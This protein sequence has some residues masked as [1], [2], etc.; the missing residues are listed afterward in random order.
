MPAATIR[1]APRVQ[2]AESRAGL[3]REGQL[4]STHVKRVDLTAPAP[5]LLA[6]E[7]GPRPRGVPLKIGFA[8]AV[9]GLDSE[10]ATASSLEWE[11]ENDGSHVAAIIVSSPTAAAIRAGLLVTDLPQDAHVR[12]QAPGATQLFEFTGREILDAIARNVVAGD[13]SADAHT[14]WSPVIEGDAIAAEI[15]LA[16]GTDPASV[17]LS[18]PT[19][20]HLATSA[21]RDF[22]LGTKSAGCEVDAMCAIDAWGPQ[23]NAV[24][25]MVF[26]GGTGTF[27]CT[28]TLMA[29]NDATSNVP[30]FLS[31]NHCISTQTSASSLTTYWFYRTSACNARTP[32]PYQQL[33]SGA[34]LLSATTATDTSFMQLNDPPP[35]GAVFAGWLAG[36]APAVGS[37]IVGLHH[38]GGDFLRISTGTINGYLACT[39]PASGNFTCDPASASSGNYLDIAW[40]SGVTEGGSSGSGLFLGDGYLVGHLYGGSSDCSAP[41]DDIYGRFDVAYDSGLKRWLAGSTA[42][43]S[44]TLVG[45]GSGTVASTPTGI[46]CGSACSANYATGTRVDLAATPAATSTFRGW[47]GACS[48]TGACTVTLDSATS[49]SAAFDPLPSPPPASAPAIRVSPASLQFGGESMATTSPSQ[50]VT[51]TNAGNAELA[52]TSLAV[53]DAQFTQ[54]SGCTTIAPGASCTVGIAF[55]P[56]VASG[57]VDTTIAV[58]ATLVLTSNDPANPSLSIALAGTAEKSLVTHYYRSILRRAPDAT[59]KAFWQGEAARV[60]SLG[61]DVDETWHAMALQFFGSAEYAALARDDAGFVSDL[62]AAFFNRA[63]DAGGLA[64]WTGQLASGLPRDAA[65]VGFLFSPEFASFTQSIFGAPGARPES[66]LV[67]DL[68]RGLLGRLPDDAGYAYWLQQIRAAQCQGAVGAAADAMSGAFASSSEAQQRN[69][70]DPQDVSD[71]YDAFLR[72]GADLTGMQYW[73]GQLA[74]GQSRDAVRQSFVASPEFSTVVA[75]VQAAGCSP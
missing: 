45:S 49:V 66:G 75:A 70:T 5:D 32:G 28:G 58:S 65:L 12:F 69:R 60:A 68:Y 13:D 18:I 29:D 11:R 74:S 8:R 40:S 41:A 48:G 56:A 72:R 63:S 35:A 54:S 67:M 64:Y 53:S 73:L 26:N 30:Y 33:S 10:D 15:A 50:T 3:A 37:T 1:V 31:A 27:L 2:S 44:I 42:T 38:P 57:P 59:G 7:L 34:T 51:I 47:S 16:P 39:A 9:P 19:I 43:L 61:A 4:R 36:A 25:K 6:K 52:I 23:M 46:A 24:A 71:L 21:T 55:T 14:Y 20:S 62:Y 17:R 22:V